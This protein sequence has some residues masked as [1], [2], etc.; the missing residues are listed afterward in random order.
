MPDVFGL[1]SKLFSN[2]PL[3]RLMYMIIIFVLILLFMPDSVPEYVQDKISIPYI[4]PVFVFAFS[5]VLAINLQR[6]ALFLRKVWRSHRNNTRE[7]KTI[8][9]I[10]AVIDSLTAGQKK[11]LITALSRNYPVIHAVRNDSDIK[12]WYLLIFC[13][14]WKGNSFPTKIHTVFCT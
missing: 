11:I 3:E 4:Y 7:Q 10:N 14:P 9:H 6:L 5:F 13:S 8:S 2:E 12:N 1:L